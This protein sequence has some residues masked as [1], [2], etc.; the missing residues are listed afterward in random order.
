[1]ELLESVL[2]EPFVLALSNVAEQRYIRTE[3]PAALSEAAKK[4]KAW[5]NAR[6]TDKV[7]APTPTPITKRV[8]AVTQPNDEVHDAS[9]PKKIPNSPPSPRTT[10]SH[11][12]E[13]KPQDAPVRAVTQAETDMLSALKAATQ[14]IT[15]AAAAMQTRQPP[16][17]TQRPQ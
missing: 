6:S 2:I 16:S 1:M 10:R 15:A 14:V 8:Q 3:A 12:K 5:E 9:Q 11:S 7:P 17:G 13:R 4:A